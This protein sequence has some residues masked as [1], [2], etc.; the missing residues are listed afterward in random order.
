MIVN[1]KIVTS[2]HICSHLFGQT[3]SFYAETEST[4]VITFT[5]KR[6]QKTEVSYY[7]DDYIWDPRLSV[8]PRLRIQTK[9]W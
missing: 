8:L 5:S 2:Y 6:V 4:F 7:V 1:N 9:G 3:Q